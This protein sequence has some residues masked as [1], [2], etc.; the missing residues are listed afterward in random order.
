MTNLI[1]KHLFNRRLMLSQ[2]EDGTSRSSDD[3][4]QVTSDASDGEDNEEILVVDQEEEEETDE[5]GTQNSTP[6][7]KSE[8]KEATNQDNTGQF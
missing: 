1:C 2:N 7:R 6:N 3:G 5:A 4:H 8:H